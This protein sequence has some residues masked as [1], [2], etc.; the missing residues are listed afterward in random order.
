MGRRMGT[1]KAL[2]TLCGETFHHRAVSALEGAGLEVLT[3]V[4]RKVNEALPPGERR[5]L[6][7]DPDQAAGMFSS[8]RLGVAEVLQQGATGAVLLP[9]DHPLVTSDDALE[10]IAR[11]TAGAA[12]VVPTHQGR[13]GHP[14]GLSGAVMAEILA[15]LS[16]T[17]LRD[18]V[19]R[20]P[21]RV[22]EAAASEGVLV[23]I[24]T[25]EDLERAS[26][27]TFR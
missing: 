2:L 8:V 16:A 6:N 5:L 3:V 19:R 12:V 7:P 13:R 20:D 18:I 23:G 22:V 17:T 11:L 27:R 15:D 24:N 4:N 14:V 21:G 26:N 25:R 1:P 9:V 10:V